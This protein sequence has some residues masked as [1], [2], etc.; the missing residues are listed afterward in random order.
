MFR[1][2][3]ESQ[4]ANV[5]TEQQNV[6]ISGTKDSIENIEAFRESIKFEEKPVIKAEM[7]I[8]TEPNLETEIQNKFKTC[9]INNKNF[10]NVI[11]KIKVEPESLMKIEDSKTFCDFEFKVKTKPT[12]I[13]TESQK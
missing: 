1:I 2:G 8:K 3:N 6:S 13:K 12:E 9:D 7:K 10:E 4:N 5:I 11:S